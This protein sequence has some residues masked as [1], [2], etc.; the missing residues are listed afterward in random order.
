MTREQL[1]TEAKS[2]ITSNYGPVIGISLLCSIIINA[3]ASAFGIAYFFLVPIE[4]GLT[5]YYVNL[6][7]G[8]TTGIG[9]IFNDAFKDRY[10]LRRVGGYAWMMLFTFLWSLL[11]VI[12]GIVKAFEYA[13]TPYILAKYPEIPA[14]DALKLSMKIMD[15][16]KSE[17]FVLY[18]SFIGWLVLSSMTCGILG[19]LYVTPYMS[20]TVTLWQKNAMREVTES[21]EFTY[22]PEVE[23]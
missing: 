16:R 10:Y 22:T 14:K 4:L 5:L 21:G 18:L 8:I 15:G 13:M 2:I 7:D 23:L 20:I 9:D 12:P 6:S 3:A 11:F 19:I 1:K 17:L